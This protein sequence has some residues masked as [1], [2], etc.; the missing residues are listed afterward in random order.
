[1]NIFL[2]GPVQVGKS[3]AI[4]RF[5]SANPAVR[6]GG[7]ATKNVPIPENGEAR[8]VYI[9]PPVWSEADLLP[10]RLTARLQ[11]GV[12]TLWPEVFDREGT[13][14]LG[15]EGP[16]DLLLMD[17]LGRM[18]LR[19]E[20]FRA[21]VLSALDGDVP[22]LGVIKPESNPF[23]DAV[24]AHPRTRVLEV[25]EENRDGI[26]GEIERLWDDGGR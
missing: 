26:P 12:W 13:A 22:V 14:L 7:F 9:L 17:E 21:A 5:L 10:S 2:T 23:L 20:R 3:T 8:G 25:T 1:V 15:A 18:E 4:K 6:P 11:G 19:A 24:R 16:F